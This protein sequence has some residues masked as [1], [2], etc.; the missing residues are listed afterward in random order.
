MPTNNSKTAMT[1]RCDVIHRESSNN[2]SRSNRRTIINSDNIQINN[3]RDEQTEQDRQIHHHRKQNQ[4]IISSHR[5]SNKNNASISLG[6]ATAKTIKT[7]EE[8]TSVVIP[9]RRKRRYRRRHTS[10]FNDDITSPIKKD[11]TGDTLSCNVKISMAKNEKESPVTVD[12]T[13][14]MPSSFKDV[15]A[16]TYQ[17]KSPT[18]VVLE[19]QQSQRLHNGEEEDVITTS[20][21]QTMHTGMSTYL[22]N[23]DASPV[24]SSSSSMSSP[25][26]RPVMIIETELSNLT[27]SQASDTDQMDHAMNI[28]SMD[29]ISSRN[30]VTPSDQLQSSMIR[31][32]E[33]E[34][35]RNVLRHQR[36]NL[37]QRLYN[38]CSSSPSFMGRSKQP[39]DAIISQ[40]STQQ[41]QQQQQRI[42]LPVPLEEEEEEESSH[43]KKVINWR[44]STDAN[45]YAEAMIL[46]SPALPPQTVIYTGYLNDTGRPHDDDGI[47]QFADG[48]IYRGSVREGQRHGWG[49]NKWPDNGQTYSG[50]W[51]HNSRCGMGTHTWKDKTVTGM[52]KD[53][54]LHGQVYFQ[55]DNGA[56]YDGNAVNGKKEG[57]GVSTLSDGSV[58]NGH[59]AKGK[60]EG[61]GTLIRPDGAKYRGQFRKGL[62]DGYG[63]MLWKDR[64]YDGQW[65][66]GKPH[67]QGRVVWSNGT[68]FT[69]EFQ[70]GK[71]DGLGVYIWPSGKKFVGRWQHGIKTGHG[72][73]TWPS[74]KKYDGEYRDGLK[75]GYGRMS[76]ADGSTYCGGFKRDQQCGRGVQIDADGQ[77][78]HCGLWKNGRPYHGDDESEASVRTLLM[79]NPMHERICI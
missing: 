79:P 40:H 56:V 43:Q 54:H 38:F 49:T 29:A 10:F 31:L 26:S 30:G 4:S 51:S 47:L 2:D 60:E 76:W 72:L 75:D 27:E 48:Q 78:I 46:Q 62:K 63:I 39:M 8:H 28:H 20:T 25:T 18:S 55:W 12:I 41:Q 1:N 61:F 58:H 16:L 6:S 13:G 73:Y 44:Y 33:L 9:S 53:G 50:E 36:F 34:L 57:R 19:P 37:E 59:F 24:E 3:C 32:H 7:T 15:T 68:V 22:S 66:K 69:G 74:G 21:M 70:Q 52:W 67:G 14:N 35:K 77:V 71:Y 64:T 42:S 5:S 17:R 23:S 11:T 45:P 65:I